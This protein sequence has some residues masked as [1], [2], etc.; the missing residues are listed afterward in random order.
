M[1]EPLNGM[2]VSRAFYDTT[3]HFSAHF[4]RNAGRPAADN[5]SFAR[6]V[7]LY[8]RL[9]PGLADN[10]SGALRGKRLV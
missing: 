10:L 8:E 5:A 6:S 2:D 1:M 9:Q 7:A 3:R 4:E